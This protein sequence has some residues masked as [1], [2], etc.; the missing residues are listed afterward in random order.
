MDNDARLSRLLSAITITGARAFRLGGRTFDVSQRTVLN[1]TDFAR[2]TG[3]L[4]TELTIQIYQHAFARLFLGSVER[5]TPDPDPDLKF[6]ALLAKANAGES[7]W[8]RGWAVDVMHPDGSLLV[9]KRERH[10]RIF[11]GEFLHHLGPGVPPRAGAFVDVR[12]P[13][14]STGQQKN[15]Y[16]AYGETSAPETDVTFGVRYYW[17]VTTPGAPFVLAG[18][19]QR[20][21]YYRIPFHL[22][23]LI[24][25][26]IHERTDSMVLYIDRRYVGLVQPIL[27]SLHEQLAR[28]L[29]D[30]TP[31][32]THRLGGGFALAET[33]LDGGSFG[34]HRCGL[35]AR[36]L[37]AA[38]GDDDSESGRR[39]AVA[40]SFADAGYDLARP[41]LN[42]GSEDI[43]G[44]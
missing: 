35:V 8:D 22:K 26:N 21:N 11:P 37:L 6:A 28:H 3:L 41:H 43:Y 20:L 36:G 17:N 19:T 18:V 29:A 16:F 33:P 25:P 32:F 15:F 40:L 42:P 27:Y 30:G 23:V 5:D 12:C 7:T 9:R 44:P 14:E 38:R 1:A 13:R 34:Y 24:C 39:A 2:P 31:W 10:R 4:E